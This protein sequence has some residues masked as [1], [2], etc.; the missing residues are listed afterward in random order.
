MTK[1]ENTTGKY[2][3]IIENMCQNLVFLA[4]YPIILRTQDG[5]VNPLICAGFC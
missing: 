3:S 4:Y 1:N 5:G 2:L